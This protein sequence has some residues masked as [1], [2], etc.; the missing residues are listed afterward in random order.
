MQAA[1][2]LELTN[3]DQ[4]LAV[5]FYDDPHRGQEVRQSDRRR[6]RDFWDRYNDYIDRAERLCRGL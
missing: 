5:S 2:N 4:R 6:D 3:S 1:A